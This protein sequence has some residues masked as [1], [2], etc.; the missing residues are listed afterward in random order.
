MGRR[1]YESLGR[2]NLPGRELWVLSQNLS[3]P[4]PAGV[5]RFPSWEVLG[6]ALSQVHKPVFFAGGEQIFTLAL[7]LPSVEYLLLSWVFTEVKG[8]VFFPTIPGS[9]QPES[10]EVFHKGPGVPVPFI[11]TRYHR[12]SV[13]Q[14]TS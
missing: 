5:Q 6:D 3:Y 7:Q 12:V 2:P 1:T 8:D 11:F 13:S 4:L 9:W 14:A 10:W